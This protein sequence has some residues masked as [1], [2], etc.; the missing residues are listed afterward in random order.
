MSSPD[1]LRLVSPVPLLVFVPSF[2]P[3]T[4]SLL[5]LPSPSSGEYLAGHTLIYPIYFDATTESVL[6][7]D[8][9]EPALLFPLIRF[10]WRQLIAL[11]SFYVS[12]EHIDRTIHSCIRSSDYP[13]GP[14]R[15]HIGGL[16]NEVTRSSPK[17]AQKRREDAGRRI[18]GVAHHFEY[19][20]SDEGEDD[21]DC[22]IL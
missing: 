2:L 16:L 6:F 17:K 20:Y 21:N 22:D 3:L 18:G 9:A 12:F 10:G 4:V 8:V 7:A 19:I 13:F 11:P 1:T 15:C 14:S 5:S